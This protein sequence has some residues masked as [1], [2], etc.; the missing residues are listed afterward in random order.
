MESWTHLWRILETSKRFTPGC[1][2]TSDNCFAWHLLERVMG[3]CGLA[4][5]GRGHGCGLEVTGR[6]V[7][8]ERCQVP[9]V[10]E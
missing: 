4:V 8:A 6:G 2:D 10:W 9:D 1:A 5:T 7:D 3:G